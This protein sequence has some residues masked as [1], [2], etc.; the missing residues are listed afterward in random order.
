MKTLMGILGFALFAIP[1]T[2]LAAERATESFRAE[3]VKIKEHLEHVRQWAGALDGKDGP[4]K[5]KDILAFFKG[6][7]APHAEMEEKTLYPLVDSLTGSGEYKFTASM[8]Y[9]HGVVGR[10]I[11]ELDKELQKP[12]PDLKAFARRTDNL[13]GLLWAHFEEEEEVLLPIVDKKLTA[14]EFNERMGVDHH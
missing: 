1:A 14:K 10:W 11:A 7:I 4:K 5:A 12:K 8:R 13:L 6:H 9:E 3:H 2:T